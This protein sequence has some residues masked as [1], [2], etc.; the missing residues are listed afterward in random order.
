MKIGKVTDFEDLVSVMST[1]AFE[2]ADKKI[3]LKK[4]IQEL[5]Q[6][7]M[8]EANNGMNIDRAIAGGI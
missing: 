5:K 2:K 8:F 4:K 7:K 3:Q 1:S 6:L